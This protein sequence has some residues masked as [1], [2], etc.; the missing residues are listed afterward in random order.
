MNLVPYRDDLFFPL[1]QTFN[2]FFEDFFVNKSNTNVAKANIGYP[3]INSYIDGEYYR[4][5]FAVP[6]VTA[7]DLEVDYGKN[8]TV[9]IKG[10]SSRK[11]QAA[12]DAKYYMREVRLSSFERTVYLP[13]DIEGEP[14][15]AV[16]SD[17]ILTLSWPIP[18]IE[19]KDRVRISVKS[20]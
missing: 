4:M 9:T 13:D 11:Y 17:G 8:K 18:P 7:D 3:K 6:G 12:S 5:A 10:K 1:E 2:K 14:E 15:N 16:L 20:E 19:N